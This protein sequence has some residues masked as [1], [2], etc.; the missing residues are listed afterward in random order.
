[1]L[2]LEIEFSREGP[3]I[4]SLLN[5][6]VRRAGRRPLHRRTVSRGRRRQVLGRTPDR[7]LHAPE[8]GELGSDKRRRTP[9]KQVRP[10][11][12]EFFKPLGDA[13]VSLHSYLISQSDLRELKDR[14]RVDDCDGFHEKGIYFPEDGVDPI[15]ADLL[16]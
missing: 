13:D 10:R 6:V 9:R 7:Q 1:M 4:C 16:D 5:K 2:Y 14:S 12:P 8:D 3:N 11:R 15:F